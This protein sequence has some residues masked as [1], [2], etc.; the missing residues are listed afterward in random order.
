[1]EI[2]IQIASKEETLTAAAELLTTQFR[3]ER[4][5][6]IHLATNQI[7]P[8]LDQ[9]KDSV[10]TLIESPYVD[11]VYRDSYYHYFSSKLGNYPKD[12]IKLSFFDGQI[13][14]ND[15]RDSQKIEDL[16]NRFYG[17]IVI[18]PT[19]PIIIGRSTISPRG[20]K[21]N[22]FRC[23]VSEIQTSVN[24]IKL[25]VKGFPHS[26]QDTETLTCAET[27][28]WAL[29]EYFANRYPEY[30]PVLPSG[31]IETLK[32]AS[33]ERQVP[34]KGLNIQQMSFAL[35]EFGFG[36]RI[37]SEAS[38]KSEFLP[39]LST[40]VES[41]I[42]V[43][44]ALENRHK[45][46]NIGHAILCIG[47][48]IISHDQI[49]SLNIHQETNVSVSENLVK[50]KI[51]VF[52]FH[53]IRKQ[54]IFIDDNLPAYQRGL[55]KSPVLHYA[56]RNW[57]NCEI[58]HFIVPLYPKIHL[59]AFEAKNYCKRFLLNHFP[60]IP[61]GSEIFMR[62]FLASSRSYKNYA[63][64]EAEFDEDMREL[65]CGTAMPKFIWICELTTKALIKTQK[66]NGLI[67]LDATEANNLSNK[68]LIHGIFL[69][70]LISFDTNIGSFI[71]GVFPFSNFKTFPK[72]LTS[73]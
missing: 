45:G 23:C 28:I 37:Y 70:K 12:C 10:W 52:D 13:E 3:I 58:T 43:I 31:I 34:S 40:Y 66:A 67:I 9:F 44:V 22:N 36:T 56:D 15:F 69:N 4:S 47:H 63:G 14:Y 25:K 24:S 64:L 62:F 46:G 27:T 6:A 68:P 42:P 11:K 19:E 38:F 33:A 8:H 59:E 57:Q 21:S 18:R 73:F 35:R 39:L 16:Q 54:F 61:D 30:K 65:I 72:N 50:R 49:D 20:L 5:Y 32:K 17:F 29:M 53:D 1:M 48:E 41:G 60:E 71:K 55:L 2:E 51:S 26:S 7:K